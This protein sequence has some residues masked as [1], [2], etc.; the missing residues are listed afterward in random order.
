MANINWNAMEREEAE[1]D[2]QLESGEITPAQHR[3]FMRELRQAVE[4]QATTDNGYSVG[5][6]GR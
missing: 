4:D 6:D 2:A 5:R 1:L 3:Q